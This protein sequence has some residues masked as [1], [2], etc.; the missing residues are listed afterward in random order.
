[1]SQADNVRSQLLRIMERND[2][3]LLSI[4]DE[5]KLHDAIKRILVC[6][7]F[8]QVAHKQGENGSYIT[9]K[10][11]QVSSVTNPLFVHHGNLSSSLCYI[12]LVVLTQSP[13]G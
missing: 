5:R 13:S 2:L 8:M 9:A 10:D 7:L 6:G 1:M 12:L 3:D 11:D 4:N